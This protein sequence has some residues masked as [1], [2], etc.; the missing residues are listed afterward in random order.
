MGRGGTTLTDTFT[1]SGRSV[2]AL[3]AAVTQ[4]EAFLN[5][6]NVQ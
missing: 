3:L 4:S 5:R 2:K 1:S 6:L